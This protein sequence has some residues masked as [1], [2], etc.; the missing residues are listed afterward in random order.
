VR[1]KYFAIEEL[2]PPEVHSLLGDQAW[3]LF[4]PS[5]LLTLDALREE[6]G[7]LRIN[8]WH[9]G[10]TYK[11]SG[12]R[13]STSPTGA[14]QSKHKLGQAFDLKPSRITPRELYD[15]ILATPK[16]WPLLTTLENI[17]HTPTWVHFDVRANPSEGIRIVNP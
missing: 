17:E 2:V 12:Y 14:P 7:P 16:R 4:D 9:I 5:A 15:G 1:C 10:G 6:F 3:D 8:N 13:L 11:E